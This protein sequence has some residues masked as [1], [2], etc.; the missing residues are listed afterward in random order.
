MA[1]VALGLGTLYQSLTPVTFEGQTVYNYEFSHGTTYTIT[2]TSSVVYRFGMGVSGQTNVASS[3]TVNMD[4]A[5]FGSKVYFATSKISGEST[6]DNFTGSGNGRNLLI[7]GAM[8]T[9]RGLVI[10]TGGTSRTPAASRS[11]VYLGNN[12]TGHLTGTYSTIVGGGANINIRGT[13][14]VYFGASSGSQ[15]NINL[16]PSTDGISLHNTACQLFCSDPNKLVGIIGDAFLNATDDDITI[17]RYMTPKTNVF[18]YIVKFTANVSVSLVTDDNITVH[19]ASSNVTIHSSVFQ[20]SIKVVYTGNEQTL[21]LLNCIIYPD[22]TTDSDNTDM[23]VITVESVDDTGFTDCYLKLQGDTVLHP[24]YDIDNPSEY[25]IVYYGFNPMTVVEDAMGPNETTASPSCV[26]PTNG[27]Y[28]CHDS[29]YDVQLQKLKFKIYG[30]L[31]GIQTDL[32]DPSTFRQ[33][34][35][36]F[37]DVDDYRLYITV[38]SNAD[39]SNGDDSTVRLVIDCRYGLDLTVMKD[40]VAKLYDGN[41]RL[42]SEYQ[43]GEAAIIFHQESASNIIFEPNDTVGGDVTVIRIYPGQKFFSGAAQSFDTDNYMLRMRTAGSYSFTTTD[44]NSYD[45]TNLGK[46]VF[47]SGDNGDTFN[48]TVKDIELNIGS[49][50]YATEVNV[51]LTVGE[52][53]VDGVGGAGGSVTFIGE[54]DSWSG[55]LI[56]ET[57]CTYTISGEFHDYDGEYNN[58]LDLGASTSHVFNGGVPALFRIRHN[59]IRPYIGN[60]STGTPVPSAAAIYLY[61]AEYTYNLT[62]ADTEA[63]YKL[64]TH[65]IDATATAETINTAT[66]SVQNIDAVGLQLQPYGG[67]DSGTDYSLFPSIAIQSTAPF[68][69]IFSLNTKMAITDSTMSNSDDSTLGIINMVGVSTNYL[70]IGADVTFNVYGVGTLDYTNLSSQFVQ[71]TQHGEGTEITVRLR[72]NTYDFSSIRDHSLDYNVYAM[73]GGS[74]F[75][76]SNM[77]Q[78]LYMDV[79]SDVS[80][81]FNGSTFDYGITLAVHGT[82]VLEDTT[83]VSRDTSPIKVSGDG[84]FTMSGSYSVTLTQ[85]V[86]AL[87]EITGGEST[88][89]IDVTNSISTE[90]S[91][92]Y[93]YVKTSQIGAGTLNLNSTAPGDAGVPISALMTPVYWPTLADAGS[94]PFTSGNGLVAVNFTSGPDRF[95]LYHGDEVADSGMHYIESSTPVNSINLVFCSGNAS[96]TAG[97][98]IYTYSISNYKGETDTNKL[99]AVFTTSVIEDSF[100]GS[101][102]GD[103]T[104]TLLVSTRKNTLPIVFNTNGSAVYIGEFTATISFSGI[105]GDFGDI[106]NGTCQLVDENISVPTIVDQTSSISITVLN[107]EDTSPAVLAQANVYVELTGSF[108]LPLYI[109]PATDGDNLPGS[110]LFIYENY[111][112][113]GTYE[114]FTDYTNTDNNANVVQIIGAGNSTFTLYARYTSSNGVYYS[115]GCNLEVRLYSTRLR[116][117]DPVL[118][119]DDIPVN[120]ELSISLRPLISIVNSTTPVAS[121]AASYTLVE[122]GDAVDA[123]FNE[124]CSKKFSEA[125]ATYTQVFYIGSAVNTLDTEGTYPNHTIELIP[126]EQTAADYN[127]SFSGTGVSNIDGV[128]VLSFSG[129]E[130]ELQEITMTAS[131][132]K[133]HSNYNFGSTVSVTIN[134]RNT[135]DLKQIGVGTEPSAVSGETLAITFYHKMPKVIFAGFA[136]AEIADD[137][138]VNSIYASGTPSNYEFGKGDTVV[139][140]IKSF[141]KVLGCSNLNVNV[142][143]VYEGNTHALVTDPSID[144]NSSHQY[145]ISPGS[146]STAVSYVISNNARYSN[147]A[148]ITFTIDNAQYGCS[149]TFSVNAPTYNRIVD[150]TN[151]DVSLTVGSGFG[152]ELNSNNYIFSGT[153]GSS[154][155]VASFSDNHSSSPYVQAPRSIDLMTNLTIKSNAI[156][157]DS[158]SDIT[159]RANI[160]VKSSVSGDDDTL[161]TLTIGSTSGV[162]IYDN[163]NLTGNSNKSY[164]D[165]T[166]SNYDSDNSL[167]IVLGDSAPT[168]IAKLHIFVYLTDHCGSD[169]SNTSTF[170]NLMRGSDNA[171]KIV[172]C[173]LSDATSE[174]VNARYVNLGGWTIRVNRVGELVFRYVGTVVGD[175]DPG[176]GAEYVMTIPNSNARLLVDKTED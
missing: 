55:V 28:F 165:I 120:N 153:T 175:S 69:V 68:T 136:S 94:T 102:D 13:S 31:N 167:Y 95:Q 10:E 127:V 147:D 75:V 88:T 155:V 99:D 124:D 77:T 65:L 123:T 79:P 53:A 140:T 159:V 161:T 43:P 89:S 81:S 29:S 40:S 128:Y 139:Y 39:Y 172:V 7:Y 9:Q 145:S 25:K 14:K 109:Y 119:T 63:W 26:L 24:Y 157:I 168:D 117:L 138:E 72:G 45:L 114:S 112:S 110:S 83:V 149:S 41:I 52:F 5:T 64:V 62:S 11:V 104:G 85:D 132:N 33:Y 27:F 49:T 131:T 142:T 15:C 74:N 125:R 130:T 16:L 44:Y 122:S 158:N 71:H 70:Y 170:Y 150:A 154:G 91:N 103:K 4:E 171:I 58:L 133:S 48:I 84:T 20:Q 113:S 163:S 98:I 35:Y 60:I 56:S 134:A 36:E 1:A 34:T 51:H 148:T 47:I 115:T 92:Y 57:S 50:E 129:N 6:G 111:S 54:Y 174:Q 82:A 30:G 108:A 3:V 38:G 106:T 66:Y 93:Y 86:T 96:F 176:S 76:F 137:D 46:G 162:L 87:I 32:A 80:A 90:G 143:R 42:D 21:N 59:G 173:N 107:D 8:I 12:S 160:I 164:V 121:N 37:E 141:G 61:E 126:D 101:L 73:G 18:D 97:S 23:H 19:I 22:T 166:A 135:A 146:Y 17:N 78:R 151:T 67:G 144:D 2:G 118:T 152:S 116:D 105:T 169:L 100:F 156:P